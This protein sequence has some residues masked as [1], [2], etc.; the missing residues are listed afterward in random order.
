MRR[1]L[2]I[3]L[4]ATTLGAA[5]SAADYDWCAPLVIRPDQRFSDSRAC[6]ADWSQAEIADGAQAVFMGSGWAVGAANPPLPTAPI[7]CWGADTYAAD[8]AYID[9][10]N[11]LRKASGKPPLIWIYS[12]RFDIVLDTIMALPGFKPGFL[13]TTRRPF[14]EVQAFFGD[15]HSPACAKGCSWSDAAV[16]FGRKACTGDGQCLKEMIDAKSGEPGAYK[17]KVFY[18][19]L[20]HAPVF[21]P[22]AVVARLDDPEYR[23]WRIQEVQHA[24]QDGHFTHVDLNHKLHN[25]DLRANGGGYWAGAPRAT[26]VSQ[27]LAN[28]LEWSAPADGYG[29]EQYVKGL[30]ALAK[31]LKAARIPFS[32]NVGRSVWT[33]PEG[34]DDPSTPTDEAALIRGI[35]ERDASVVLLSAD[36]DPKGAER[37]AV[38]IRRGP[39]APIVIP[40]DVNCG[41]AKG[42]AAKRAAPAGH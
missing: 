24:L 13:A 15:D 5:A 33:K 28:K 11:A 20:L 17:N 42:T 39:S 16:G 1:S 12:N 10:V 2:F 22:S 30:A 29:Y 26:D 35:A 9:K 40:Y 18:V 32:F 36:G 3:L 25:Y 31:E 6:V 37:V 4:L 8:A 21:W 14:S 34:S 23:A 38:Q 41:Y 19:N 7:T 27:M